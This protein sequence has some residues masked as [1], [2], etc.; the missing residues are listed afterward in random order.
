MV[1]VRLRRLLIK[2]VA[3]LINR[4]KLE[5]KLF[6][7]R[8]TTPHVDVPASHPRDAAACRETQEA[9]KPALRR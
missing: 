1:I 8:N 6:T 9:A 4:A 2:A 3:A 7:V 5:V